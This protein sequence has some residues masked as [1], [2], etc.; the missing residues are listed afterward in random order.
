MLN[1]LYII[2]S[3]NKI[4]IKEKNPYINLLLDIYH[5]DVCIPTTNI[6][7]LKPILLE[8]LT[9]LTHRE[10]K[11][12]RLK[13]GLDGC[14]FNTE[15]IARE[16]NITK[17]KVIEIEK[18]AIRKLLHPSR[19]AQ[20]FRTV[21]YKNLRYRT[22]YYE[23]YQEII[24][25]ALKNDIVN[26]LEN[27]EFDSMYLHQIINKYR[28]KNNLLIDQLSYTSLEEL[29]FSARTRRCLDIAQ[30]Y[31]L[32]D[33]L[34]YDEDIMQ[35]KNLGTKSRNEIFNKLLTL[36]GEKIESFPLIQNLSDSL[37]KDYLKEKE[38]I[39]IE[40]ILSRKNND[41]ANFNFDVVCDSVKSLFDIDLSPSLINILLMN[42]YYNIKQLFNDLDNV[43][44]TLNTHGYSKEAKEL[45]DKILELSDLTYICKLDIN[46]F[47]FIYQNN[48][49]TFDDF[50]HLSINAPEEIKGTV[51]HIINCVDSSQIGNIRN[52]EFYYE[53]TNVEN[54]YED[55]DDLGLDFDDE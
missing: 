41:Y 34:M 23:N 38:Q 28:L 22:T 8:M 3:K 39:Q 35:I 55:N 15:K 33:I 44:G 29:D 2:C 12:L 9:L 25:Q 42:G 13:H 51:E 7:F 36:C 24:L 21:H 48:I 49:N 26:Y 43:M 27:N 4:E 32:H 16:F 37:K 14:V 52:I 5:D 1:N 54:Y 11:I 10:E 20:L 40:L 45:Y 31:T 47:N 19:T 17:T 18:K 30:L 50:K 6:E 53:S 46:L